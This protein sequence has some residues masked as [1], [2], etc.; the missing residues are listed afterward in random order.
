MSLYEVKNKRGVLLA[1]LLVIL[2]VVQAWV[3][4]RGVW[5]WNLLVSHGRDGWALP[6]VGAGLGMVAIVGVVG[7][8]LWWRWAVYLLAAVV[9]VGVV[10]D[11]WFGLP[12]IALLIR[13]VLLGLLAWLI[14][15]QWSSFR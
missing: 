13:L 2:A 5:T 9:A 11:V 4:F 14:R 15:A 1:L 7:V 3:V 8:W 6:L 10:S 12:P